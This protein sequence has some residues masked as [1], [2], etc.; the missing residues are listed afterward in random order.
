MICCP[1]VK[2]PSL[3]TKNCFIGWICGK[4]GMFHI[5]ANKIL[6]RGTKVTWNSKISYGNNIIEI[7]RSGSMRVQ[8]RKQMLVLLW[9]KSERIILMH[10]LRL[11][12]IIINHNLIGLGNPSLLLVTWRKSNKLVTFLLDVT[13]LSTV[14]AYRSSFTNIALEILAIIVVWR[15]TLIESLVLNSKCSWSN[16]RKAIRGWRPLP[17]FLDHQ[18]E[19]LIYWWNRLHH[20]DLSLHLWIA[21]IQSIEKLHDWILMIKMC[22]LIIYSTSAFT[23]WPTWQRPEIQQV[24]PSS[25][26]IKEKGCHRRI[27]LHYRGDLLLELRNSWSIG[28]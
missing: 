16:K 11:T 1:S 4:N 15:R 10:N 9:S 19:S 2:N 14:A 22:N 28:L 12:L 3:L 5:Q 24:I 17:F 26:K 27:F 23:K 18:W 20:K 13:K 25:L 7:T 6:K 8:Q 21:I